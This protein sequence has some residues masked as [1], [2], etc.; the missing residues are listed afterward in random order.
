MGGERA[1]K[2]IGLIDSRG[3]FGVESNTVSQD[4]LR[5]MCRVCVCVCVAAVSFGI[6]AVFRFVL[7]RGNIMNNNGGG[8]EES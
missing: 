7:W 6:F 1:A 2:E 4:D 5:R 8:G 3:S